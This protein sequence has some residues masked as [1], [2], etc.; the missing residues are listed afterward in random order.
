MTSFKMTPWRFGGNRVI[1]MEVIF[2]HTNGDRQTEV[3]KISPAHHGPTT[4]V[5]L[6][7]PTPLSNS[8]VV[9]TVYTNASMVIH[10]SNTRVWF[11]SFTLSEALAAQIIL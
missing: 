5:G 11:F 3:Q 4:A 7:A 10:Y 6:Q 9:F 2:N 1:S 8:S